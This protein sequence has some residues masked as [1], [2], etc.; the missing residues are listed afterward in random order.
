MYSYFIKLQLDTHYTCLLHFSR[1]KILFVHFWAIKFFKNTNRLL[2]GYFSTIY[3]SV[4][5]FNPFSY[6]K[7]SQIIKLLILCL[8]LSWG[9][10]FKNNS[11]ARTY[12]TKKWLE[13]THY[14]IVTVNEQ[15]Y[16][17]KRF[18]YLNTQHFEK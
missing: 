10:M 8:H 3:L 4:R 11:L 17:L 14:R 7:I 15:F 13:V 9:E 16:R 1:R 12:I 5:N 18:W 6:E 2:F